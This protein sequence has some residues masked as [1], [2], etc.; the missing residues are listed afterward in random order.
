MDPRPAD[1]PPLVDTR[2]VVIS[3]AD[4]KHLAGH[5]LPIYFVKAV[6]VMKPANQ[7]PSGVDMS[8]LDTG[9]LVTHDRVTTRFRNAKG[10]TVE[11]RFTRTAYALSVLD[12]GGDV[13]VQYGT[14]VDS[15]PGVGVP[16]E[17]LLARVTK[18]WPYITQKLVTKGP[19]VMTEP[20]LG[21][22][23]YPR[24][25]SGAQHQSKSDDSEQKR[26]EVAASFMAQ[27]VPTPVVQMTVPQHSSMAS[28]GAP[29]FGGGAPASVTSYPLET[30]EEPLPPKPHV[31][32]GRNAYRSKGRGSEG[33]R[34]KP[35]FRSGHPL[36]A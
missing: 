11:K 15:Y 12:M 13:H 23:V 18:W 26:E 36:D 27:P 32:R 1:Y 33:G 19:D 4:G 21:F 29:A 30:G 35:I 8:W 34:Q 28:C 31:R 22:T 25:P 5:E 14:I 9:V 2:S 6:R 10:K 7:F 17:H 24:T 20:T 16:T 3:F